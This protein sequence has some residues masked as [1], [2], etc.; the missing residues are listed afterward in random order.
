MTKRHSFLNPILFV[1]NSIHFLKTNAD[2]FYKRKKK[3]VKKRHFSTLTY[4]TSTKFHAC[5]CVR[6]IIILRNK[7]NK[8]MKLKIS[9]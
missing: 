7:S 5:A 8:R 3:R 4:K 2:I 9:F 1:L 6:C